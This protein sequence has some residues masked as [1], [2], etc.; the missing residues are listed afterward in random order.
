MLKACFTAGA[1][2]IELVVN[3]IR[4]GYRLGFDEALARPVIMYFDEAV[5]LYRTIIDSMITASH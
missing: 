4:V 1:A 2:E 3:F 5:L